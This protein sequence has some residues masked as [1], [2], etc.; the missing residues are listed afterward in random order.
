MNLL[1]I[2]RHNGGALTRYYKKIQATSLPH[3]FQ[4][5]RTLKSGEKPSLLLQSGLKRLLG[6]IWK[7]FGDA[8]A[9]L[10][11]AVRGSLGDFFGI[12]VRLFGQVCG[13]CWGGL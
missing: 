8:F 12:R 9:K 2:T 1:V 7:V 4:P 10:L 11:A 5:S 6:H 3:L 13:Q